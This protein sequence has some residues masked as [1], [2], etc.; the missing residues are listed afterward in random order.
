MHV[1][2]HVVSI[3][4]SVQTALVP[5]I[6]VV[7]VSLRIRAHNFLSSSVVA[8]GLYDLAKLGKTSW[9]YEYPPNT[10]SCLSTPS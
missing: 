9:S 2:V 7:S 1:H 6:E 5:V 8:I 10:R 3:Y 4:Y